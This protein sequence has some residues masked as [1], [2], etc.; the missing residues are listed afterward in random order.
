MSHDWKKILVSPTDSIQ[1]VLNVIDKE[2][3]RMALVVDSELRLL[4]TVSDG[5]VRRALIL[6]VSLSSP[7]SEIMFTTPVTA[8]FNTEK[9]KLLEIMKDKQKV[10]RIY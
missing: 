6:N 2:A 4:G 7:I 1:Q 3:L 9:A 5:D 10:L 8:A